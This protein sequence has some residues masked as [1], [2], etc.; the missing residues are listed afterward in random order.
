[1]N[2]KERMLAAMR[3]KP[4]D[5]VPFSTIDLH[6]YAGSRHAEDASYA[7][8]LRRI[9]QCAGVFAKIG[10]MP[11]AHGLGRQ[12]PGLVERRIDGVGEGRLRN[13]ILH[14]PKGNLTE[15]TGIPENGPL[16]SSSRSSPVT[17][18]SRLISRCPTSRP[19]L[20]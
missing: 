4:V 1:M 5:R 10:A 8:L 6:P 16:E 14:T 11:L 12:R 3:R 2:R 19:R 20:T 18:T 9:E 17:R 15:T 13:T 7:P